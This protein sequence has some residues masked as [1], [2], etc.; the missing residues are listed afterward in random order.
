MN[1]NVTFALKWGLILGLAIFAAQQFLAALAQKALP[2][3]AVEAPPA[4]GPDV[5][6]FCEAFPNDPLCTDFGGPGEAW[7]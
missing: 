6:P 5:Q 3:P 2:A 4:G 1:E 7:I